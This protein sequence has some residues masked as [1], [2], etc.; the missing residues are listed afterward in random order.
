[1]AGEKQ[2]FRKKALAKLA[3]PEQLDTLMQVTQPRGW[4]ALA[5]LGAV[6]IVA[7]IWSIVGR[8]NV[9]VDGTGILIRGESVQAV[10]SGTAGRL[11]ALK[12]R[13]GDRIEPGQV[14]AELEQSQLR[15]RA[16]N[17][18][19][20]LRRLVEQATKRRATEETN[21]ARS[22]EAIDKEYESVTASLGDYQR[23]IDALRDQVAVQEEM[24]ERGLMT[25]ATLL[26]TQNQLAR[27]RQDL[28]RARVRLAQIESE[29]MS[30]RRSYQETIDARQNRIE[31][32][33]AEL[34]E[35]ESQLAAT[36][37]VTAPYGGRVLEITSNPGDLVGAG[38][39]LLTLESVDAAIEAVFYVSAFKGKK[40]QEGM[41]VRISPSTVKSEEYG[42]MIGEVEK[43]SDFPV[44]PQGLRRVLRND[45]LVDTLTGEG[46]PLE[47]VARLLPDPDTPSG[48]EWSSG[49]GPPDEI[50]SGTLLTADVI[51]ESKRPIEYVLPVF[52]G[53]TAAEVSP[54]AD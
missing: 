27:A 2:L 16:E 45:K 47:V 36:A 22:E 12:V 28:S 44:T 14:V 30:L 18:R 21:L 48:F 8:I 42:F 13:V 24:V 40:I 33:S 25:A 37:S 1:M 9:K 35:L 3:S 4:L 53:A 41:R 49:D 46:A 19:E 39:P 51:V 5:G 10:S 29:R 34:E 6:L 32:L 43:V 54:R 11:L 50:F 17:T 31:Q 38:V 26:S 20:Q 23:Q 7:I 15:L 52:K